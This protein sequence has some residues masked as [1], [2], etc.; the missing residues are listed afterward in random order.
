MPGC[1]PVGTTEVCTLADIPA[2]TT[3]QGL[4]IDDA[5]DETAPAGQ[6]LGLVSDEHAADVQADPSDLRSH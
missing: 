4:G 1:S 3:K 6:Q 2:H 5:L